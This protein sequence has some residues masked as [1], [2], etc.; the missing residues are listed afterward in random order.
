MPAESKKLLLFGDATVDPTTALDT[1]V[2]KSYAS[3]TVRQLLGDAFDTLKDEIE[4]DFPGELKGVNSF[5]AMLD[6]DNQAEH[7]S[8]IRQISAVV[9][10]T[11]AR[12]AELVM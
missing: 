5:Y 6:L 7:G 8:Q 12:I 3:N 11:V 4:K 1:A 9:V 2:E 10:I